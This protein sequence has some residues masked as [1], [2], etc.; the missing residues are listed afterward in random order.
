MLSTQ[1]MKRLNLVREMKERKEVLKV[2][3]SFL[4]VYIVTVLIGLGFFFA[5][6]K[7]YLDFLIK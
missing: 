3:Q 2:M 5:I 4:L 1:K 7:G 6:A